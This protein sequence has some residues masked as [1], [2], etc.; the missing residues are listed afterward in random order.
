MGTGTF[1]GLAEEARQARLLV[2][3]LLGEDH[4]VIDE[5]EL[6]TGEIFANAIQHTASGRPGGKVTVSVADEG[7]AIRVDITD[8]GAANSTPHV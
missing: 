4:P 1:A 7:S 5:A 2:R 6:L 8:E 3:G